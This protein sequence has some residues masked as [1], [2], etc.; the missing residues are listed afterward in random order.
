ML[1]IMRRYLPYLSLFHLVHLFGLEKKMAA[2]YKTDQTVFDSDLTVPVAGTVFYL[3]LVTVGPK[4][5]ARKKAYVLKDAM[6]AYNAYQVLY[7]TWCCYGFVREVMGN[8]YANKLHWWGNAP[9]TIG[10]NF[11][12]GF[13]IWLH[14]NNKYLEFFDTIFM[15]LRKKNEQLSFLHIYHHT[16]IAWAWWVVTKVNCGGDSYFGALCNS[17][18]HVLMYAYYLMAALKISCPWKR[19]LTK[20]QMI[21]FLTCIVHAGYLYIHKTVPTVLLTLQVFMMASMFVL[22]YVFYMRKYKKKGKKKA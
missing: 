19:H 18:I 2:Q 10:S 13:F 6:I 17:F 22:F 16:S 12:L 14:Y 15:V 20:M 5:M 11:G 21:Q 3:L 4:I 7:N 8:G 1:S 9:E